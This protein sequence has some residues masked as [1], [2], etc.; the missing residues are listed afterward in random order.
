MSPETLD[1]GS[2][3]LNVGHESGRPGVV[4]RNRAGKTSKPEAG[5]SRGVSRRG[6]RSV[7][8]RP[9]TGGLVRSPRYGRDGGHNTRTAAIRGCGGPGEVDGPLMECRAGD[10]SMR[11][12][13]RAGAATGRS[14]PSGHQVAAD[15]GLVE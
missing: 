15:L 8:R 7:A 5:L 4:G 13:E 14:R 10:P 11:R 3:I 1:S 2:G 12:R 9:S 6:S